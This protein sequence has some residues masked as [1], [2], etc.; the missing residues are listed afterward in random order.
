MGCTCSLQ[1]ALHAD[2]FC[3]AHA[4]RVA[5]RA[6]EQHTWAHT[7]WRIMRLLL[8]CA[9][10]FSVEIQAELLSL[11]RLIVSTFLPQPTGGP[12]ILATLQQVLGVSARTNGLCV[13]EFRGCTA[14]MHHAERHVGSAQEGGGVAA[15]A[16]SGHACSAG[17]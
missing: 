16:G 7:A 8:G 11:M 10:V 9:Q 12:A 6:C 3:C 5:P 14:W 1:A 15:S 4:P 2:L 13:L 17:G